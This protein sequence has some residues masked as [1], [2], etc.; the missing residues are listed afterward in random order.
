MHIYGDASQEVK[1]AAKYFAEKLLSKSEQKGLD[2]EINWL[3]EEDDAAELL[4][5]DDDLV[6]KCF[7]I[8][9][10]P[11]NPECH[12][13]QSLAHE[14]V[15]VRQYVS[16]QLRQVDGTMYWNDSLIDMKKIRY[17]DLPWEI[18][19]HALEEDLFEDYLSE[20]VV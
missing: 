20:E 12:S 19:A 3:Y 16:G 7:T 11:A 4:L 8:N 14:M 9:I 5:D 15:H 17:Y 18:E 13:I 6:P 1:D 10:N 2:L